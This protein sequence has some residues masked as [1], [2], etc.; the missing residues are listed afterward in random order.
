[1]NVQD[2]INSIT[3][4]LGNQNQLLKAILILLALLY[5]LFTLVLA[6]QITLLTNILN[7]VSFT[8]IFRFLAYAVAIA[9]LGL[10]LVTIFV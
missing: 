4:L 1:M 3:T 9:T 8:P 10:L 6:R 5:L 2:I 7:Q